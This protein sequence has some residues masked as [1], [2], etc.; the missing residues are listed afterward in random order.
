MLQLK[1]ETRK[2]LDD[3]FNFIFG[4]LLPDPEPTDGAEPRGMWAALESCALELA[5]WKTLGP[6]EES[7]RVMTLSAELGVVT[8]GAL[9]PSEQPA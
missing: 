2:Y 1:R 3:F 9:T 4:F 8:P 5:L 7:A 6:T